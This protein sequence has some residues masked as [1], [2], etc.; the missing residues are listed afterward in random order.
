MINVAWP[1][2]E[3]QFENL[4]YKS[5]YEKVQSEINNVKDNPEMISTMNALFESV[6]TL[7]KQSEDKFE[8]LPLKE[9]N[10]EPKKWDQPEINIPTEHT[11]SIYNVELGDAK[12]D[13]EHNL[14][15][16]KRSTINEYGTKWYTYHENYHDFF[17][18]T[19]DE[20]NKVAGLYTNQD[21]ITSS[22]GI[23]MGSPKNLVLEK[24]G[25]PLTNL[26]KGMVQ[27]QL[28]EGSDYHLILLDDTYVTVFYDQ[29]KGNTV[30]ALQLISKE[31]EQ[32][33]TDFYTKSSDELKEGFELQMFD[34]TNAT[35]VKHKLP[36]LNWD[37]H[38]KETARKHSLDM[39]ENKYFD[40]TNS[41]GQSPFDRMKEDNVEFILAGENLAYGQ[42]SSIFA[43]EGLMNSLGHRE[44]ILHEKFKY[45]GIGVAFNNQFHP[46]YTQN[47]F[48]N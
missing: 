24:L 47:Y 39:A 46:Y 28:S 22:N 9:L 43:H 12:Q 33:K 4:D 44:N 36:I 13:I 26:Q 10:L 42:L 41:Q 6:L 45:L 34:L 21:L 18:I 8:E 40:H 48:A 25:E 20:N 15:P 35:R 17:M 2:I 19:Y 29:H 38:V 23:K 37:D 1:S 3:N 32:S 7:L 31:L 27:Y 30:T 5:T 16:S 14:G 11:F